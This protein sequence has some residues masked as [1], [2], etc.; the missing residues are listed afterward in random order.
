MS[1]TNSAV[2]YGDLLKR[3][4]ELAEAV[5]MV[6]RAAERAARAEVLP[7]LARDFRAGMSAIEECE[8]IARALYGAGARELQA[9]RSP[10]WPIET[11]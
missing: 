7:A 5:H 11:P 2:E 6:R 9:K 1:E 8:A 10:H 4:H 3:Y